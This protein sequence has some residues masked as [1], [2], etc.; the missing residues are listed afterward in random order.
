MNQTNPSH[1]YDAY[2]YRHCCGNPYERTQEWLDF[3]GRIADVIVRR[4]QPQ[5]VL[6]VGCAMGFLVE[7][8][9][10]RNIDAHGIDVSEYAIQHVRPDLQPYCHVSSILEP[11]PRR[12]DLIVSI[13]VLEHLSSTLCEDAIKNICAATDDVLF[14]S[15]P[16]DYREPTHVNVQPLEYWA[17]FFA[18]NGFVRDFD[19]DASFITPWAVR[20][21]KTTEPW[22][23][24][25]RLY[26][27]REWALRKENE[28]LRGMALDL[29]NRLAAKES[30]TVLAVQP[31]ETLESL[32][33]QL[34]ERD[35]RL[36]QITSAR[37]SRWAE[38]MRA[39]RYRF[40]PSQ[41][42]RERIFLSVWQRL[43][44]K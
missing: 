23:R 4:I 24:I 15:T 2:Y 32:E 28:E 21:R 40:A 20:F 33:S 31:K 36:T 25:I 19:F 13:E 43:V 7:S 11:L 5:T 14:S 38:Q 41:S 44:G 17:E 16:F 27:R 26:E 39:L 29:R 1:L 3:F 10:E 18:L 42:Q 22:H 8:L 34:A 30:T 6:D 37:S 9:R 12:Y 35:R